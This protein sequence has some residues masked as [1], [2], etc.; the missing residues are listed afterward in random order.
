MNSVGCCR[1]AGRVT[2][3][4]PIEL[5]ELRHPT[6]CVL[7]EQP[8]RAI[9]RGFSQCLE[10]IASYQ[11]GRH[12]IRSLEKCRECGQLYFYDWFEWTERDEG[13]DWAL[14]N[15]IPVQTEAEI[16]ALKQASSVLRY[17]PRLQMGGGEAA[18]VGKDWESRRSEAASHT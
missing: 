17:W 10:E 8:E 14:S 1:S 13:V 2:E 7:W 18:W 9:G 5:V 6:Q 15:L 12:R 11:D 4:K 16:E 3:E